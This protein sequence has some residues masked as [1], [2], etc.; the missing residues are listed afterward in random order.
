MSEKLNVLHMGCRL[1]HGPG[2]MDSIVE[3]MK[4]DP[5]G[6]LDPAHARKFRSWPFSEDEMPEIIANLN[7]YLA[8]PGITKEI[9]NSEEAYHTF[10][11]IVPQGK[12]I[13]ELKL[14]AFGLADIS[15]IQDSSEKNRL[16][17]LAKVKLEQPYDVLGLCPFCSGDILK[18]PEKTARKMVDYDASLLITPER[19]VEL[20]RRYK[21]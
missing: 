11:F 18:I 6:T 17:E 19:I 4:K 1:F 21:N 14:E 2:F 8:E 13:L 16:L 15:C 3:F 20:A 9:K 7:H 5:R 12:G 10:D